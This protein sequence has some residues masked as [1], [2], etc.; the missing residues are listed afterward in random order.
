MSISGGFGVSCEAG[1]DCELVRFP[2][3][4]V[5]CIYSL[6]AVDIDQRFTLGVPFQNIHRHF[7]RRLSRGET[8]TR[9]ECIKSRPQIRHIRDQVIAGNDRISA[10][11]R[12]AQTGNE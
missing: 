11:Q 10:A 7:M 1:T 12:P 2:G 6:Q 3:D 4:P 5:G 8:S 9:K